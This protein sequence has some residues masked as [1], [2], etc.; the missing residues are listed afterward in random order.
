VQSHLTVLP[1]VRPPPAAPPAGTAPALQP[2]VDE[3]RK[4]PRSAA[5]ARDAVYRFITAMACDRPGYEEALRALYRDDAA[6]FCEIIA[7]WPKDV[8]RY[9]AELLGGST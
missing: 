4:G 7:D 5:A 8:C 1:R 3:A 6:R 2:P 9:T